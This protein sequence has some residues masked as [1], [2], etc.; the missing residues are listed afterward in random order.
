MRTQII[1]ILKRHNNMPHIEVLSSDVLTKDFIERH[2][3]NSGGMPEHVIKGMV[4]RYQINPEG[5]FAVSEASVGICMYINTGELFHRDLENRIKALA[6]EIQ[7]QLLET[8]HQAYEAMFNEEQRQ[9]FERGLALLL[10]EEPHNQELQML[11]SMI[12]DLPED[13]K[14]L[15]PNAWDNI[16]HG[17]CL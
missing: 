2:L 8:K 15:C 17:L 12:K 14:K 5:T 6:P 4:D 1:F 3:R 16:L 13:H 11:H 9:L 10:K 7:Q